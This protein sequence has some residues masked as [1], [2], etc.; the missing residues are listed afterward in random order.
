VVDI[1]S[2]AVRMAIADVHGDGST[3]LLERTS[4]PV[5]LGHDSF[6]Q[7][8]LSERSI[9]AAIRVLRDYTRLMDTYEVSM[10]RAVATSAA[11]DASNGD[12]FLERIQM[13]VGMDVEVID[14]MEQSRLIVAALRHEAEKD[15]NLSGHVVAI[16]EVGGGSTLLTVLRRGNIAASQSYSLGSVRMQESLGTADEP[17]GRAADIMRHHIG[18]TVAMARKSLNLQRKR[19]FV[20][21]GGDARFAAAQVGQPLDGGS[22][23]DV[24]EADALD[25]LLEGLI[26][27]HPEQIAQ[28]HNLPPA[29]AET[30][31]PA[32]LV[33]QALLQSMRTSEMVVSQVSMRDGLLLD[34]PRFVSGEEDPEL[35]RSILQNAKT[36][37][38]RYQADIDHAEHVAFLAER[39]FDEMQDE[40]RLGPRDRLLLRVAALLHDIGMFVSNRAH[41]KHTRYLI[42]HM[43]IFGLG[44]EEVE[45]VAALARYHRRAMPK[46]SHM[47]Y[48][49]MP[50]DTRM[51][52]SKMAAILRVADALDRGHWQQVRDFT[53][54]RLDRELVFY[55]RN[56]SDLTLERH[57]LG[58][59]GNLFQEM[60]GLHVRLEE[61]PGGGIPTPEP[62]T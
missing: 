53:I 4:R 26:P 61:E 30:L 43:E 1:G 6:V 33:Y 27:M 24:V 12:A 18:N 9:N 57:A 16:A 36:I 56:V 50:R 38:S 28:R 11:R 51:A 21:I 45:K 3:T 17:P 48:K 10:T 39:I 25:K 54:E 7:D 44:R 14:P 35:T 40:H 59:K 37:A 49:A 34:L 22:D 20:A 47:E 62:G 32:L 55:V 29:D 42:S 19:T 58:E 15:L 46:Y 8:K 52:V 60:F 31:V 5:N 2:N 41:H 13:T 23:L